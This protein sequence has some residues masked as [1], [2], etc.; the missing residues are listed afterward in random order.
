[1]NMEENQIRKVDYNLLYIYIYIYIIIY[2][3]KK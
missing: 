2:I 3:N 1:M